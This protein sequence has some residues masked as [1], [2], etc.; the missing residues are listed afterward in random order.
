MSYDQIKTS[1]DE[2]VKL[3]RRNQIHNLQAALYPNTT[4]SNINLIRSKCP[5]YRQ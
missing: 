3:I 4:F 2:I 1:A 5:Q